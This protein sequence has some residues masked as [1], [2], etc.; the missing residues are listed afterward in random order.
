MLA[1]G[2]ILYFGREGDVVWGTGTN[3]KNTNRGDYRFSHL[4]VRAVRGPLTR[5]FL[6]TMFG[7][8]SPEI[9]GDPALLVPYLFPEFVR[10][11]YPA[12]PYTIIPHYSEEMHFPKEAYPHV[13]YPTEP[14]IL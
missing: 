8:E 1:L 4:D 5:Q 9:Y 6:L 10:P 12:H 7:I 2:S 13:V 11:E 14:W 3:G